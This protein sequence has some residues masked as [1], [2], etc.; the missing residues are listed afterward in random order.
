MN[1]NLDPKRCHS[2]VFEARGFGY[3][4]QNK[5][6]VTDNGNLYC[7]IHSPEYVKAKRAKQQAK[8]DKESA[9]RQVGY[10]LKDARKAATEGLTLEELKQ[11]TPE[12]IRATQDMHK[13]LKAANELTTYDF[14]GRDGYGKAKL[15]KAIDEVFE[16]TKQA[17][18]KAEGK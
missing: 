13:A 4:C 6:I 14:F 11:V 1:R 3:Q 2:W 10:A 8:W 12:L 18:A 16:L 17:L 15:Q 7:R 9:E 5:P